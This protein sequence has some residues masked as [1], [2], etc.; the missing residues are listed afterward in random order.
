MA[1]R[2]LEQ[3]AEATIRASRLQDE[4]EAVKIAH[5]EAEADRAAIQVRLDVAEAHAGDAA[6]A[7]A[8]FEA[9][10]EATTERAKLAEQQNAELRQAE[11]ERAG[12]GRWA[13]LRAA[14]RGSD[15]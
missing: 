6:G 10:L 13:R 15:I 7:L 9:D 2:T 8:K 5:G 12:R 11:A 1:H 14:W 4:L 3:L